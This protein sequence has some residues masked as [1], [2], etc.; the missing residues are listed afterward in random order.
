[1]STRDCGEMSRQPVGNLMSLWVV[2]KPNSYSPI[3][4][5]ARSGDRSPR[6]YVAITAR[7][8]SRLLR[9]RPGLQQT[10]RGDEPAR[11][12]DPEDRTRLPQFRQLPATTAPALRHRLADSTHATNQKPPSTLGGIEPVCHA[13]ILARQQLRV[14]S[15]D[16]G[17]FVQTSAQA[18]PGPR[19]DHRSGEVA[20]PTTPN[21][22]LTGPDAAST[23]R[24]GT[25]AAAP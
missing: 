10:H 16:A 19:D 4:T 11:R 21:H 14:W 3:C 9:H 1:M 18:G 15:R 20:H 6:T 2:A 5:P 7:R 23:V 25:F 13:F 8:V 17:A 22:P 12:E 24:A